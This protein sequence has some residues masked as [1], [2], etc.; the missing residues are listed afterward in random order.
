MLYNKLKSL[1]L[2]LLNIFFSFHLK[3]I[4]ERH[5]GE[6]TIRAMNFSD[7]NKINDLYFKTKELGNGKYLSY[8]NTLIL[9]ILGKKICFVVFENDLFIGYQFFY[10]NMKD[11]YY[12]TIH[13][14]SGGIAVD[15]INS[16]I[17]LLM[18]ENGFSWFMDNNFLKGIT[19]RIYDDNK[20]SLR[21]HQYFGFKIKEQIIQNDNKKQYYLEKIFSQEER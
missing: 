21:A 12:K 19:C 5:F 18:M 10:F 13:S 4:K 11:I 9:H 17:G 2:L 7:F 1:Y 3:R 20:R 14:A 8:Y 16:G 15:K 6:F